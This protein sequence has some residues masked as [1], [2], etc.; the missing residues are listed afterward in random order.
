[1]DEAKEGS[2]EIVRVSGNTIKIHQIGTVRIPTGAL[3][4]GPSRYGKE[5]FM[6][7]AVARRSRCAFFHALRMLICGK[8]CRSRCGKGPDPPPPPFSNKRKK[9]A[10]LYHFYLMK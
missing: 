10:A 1:M 3:L 2:G 5:T 7:K 4:I 8:V 9:K 6:A